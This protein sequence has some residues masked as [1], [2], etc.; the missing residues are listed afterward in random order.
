MGLPLLT[1]YGL[2]TIV[3]G[4][5]YALLGK[6]AG[7]AGMA[8]PLAFALAGVIALLS[9][10]SFAELST[11]F[12][13]SAGEAFYV[14]TGFNKP[15]LSITVGVMVI[16]TGIVSA[17]TLVVATSHFLN[18]SS[19]LSPLLIIFLLT[20]G[21]GLIA[22][23]G[24]GQ[25]AV[26]IMLITIIEVGALIY[27]CF[28][29]V[30]ALQQVGS[31]WS[32]IVFFESNGNVYW[33]GLLSGS[34]LAFYAFIGFEDMV[35]AAEEVQQVHIVMPR[36]IFLSIGLATALYIVI[37]TIAVLTVPI[38]VLSQSN[39]PLTQLVKHQ[40]QYALTGLWLVSILAG[41]NGALVQIIMASRVIYGM[42]AKHLLSSTLA[43]Q[44]ATI[45]SKTNTPVVATIVIVLLVLCLALFFPVDILAKTTSTA[46]FSIFFLVNWSLW[47]IKKNDPLLA[48]SDH[49]RGPVFNR[50]IPFCGSITS[51]AMLLIQ[52]TQWLI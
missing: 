18:D 6:V 39:T 11:R 51:L 34:F 30:D 32:E 45:S 19:S 28:I 47:R 15:L 4:G 27:I 35:N 12:P 1:F 24:M 7:E 31:R 50:W 40:P 36:A 21:M 46:V 3:G 33:A 48:S 2:G 37:S 5:I 22:I 20:I 25:S 52:I 17:A 49:T 10:C 16:F 29:N 8:M 9:A 26:L 13:I 38:D 44:L 14:L 41:V 23:W 42:S 43:R